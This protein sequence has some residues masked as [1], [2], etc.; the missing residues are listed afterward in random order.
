MLRT[1]KL[2]DDAK[3]IIVN[4]LKKDEELEN[5]CM[6]NPPTQLSHLLDNVIAMFM[7]INKS[8]GNKFVRKHIKTSYYS[9]LMQPPKDM[10]LVKDDTN[11]VIRVYKKRK[12]EYNLRST[13]KMITKPVQGC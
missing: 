9:Q 8:D 5:A 3:K 4:Y 13:G 1:L 12:S 7:V 11:K 10:L 2:Q 6:A